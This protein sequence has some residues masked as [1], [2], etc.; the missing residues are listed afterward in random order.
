MTWHVDDVDFNAA[1]YLASMLLHG[2]TGWAVDDGHT[3][4]NGAEA[5]ALTTACGAMAC[6]KSAPREPRA[7]PI[8]R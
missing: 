4:S 6:A 8:G 7:R 1:A 2:D 3:A 5:A